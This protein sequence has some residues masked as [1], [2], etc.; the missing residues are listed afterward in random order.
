M[1]NEQRL[2]LLKQDMT[3]NGTL[4]PRYAHSVRTMEMA[5]ELNKRLNL[6][7]DEEKIYLAAMFHDCAK[8]LPEE[9]QFSIIKNNESSAFC[10]SVKDSPLVWHSFAGAYY[11]K[12]RYGILD[13]EVLEAIKYHTTGKPNMSNLEMLIFAS[14]YIES[15]RVGLWFDNA[16][17]MCYNNLVFGVFTILKQTLEYLNKNNCKIFY[18][19]KDTYTYY[20]KIVE[21]Q[22]A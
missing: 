19:T 7:I 17:K 1:T 22:N 14:D 20:Q 11:A 2:E 12:E 15:G 10:E 9:Q 21:E 3:I 18:L 16:R 8:L 4:H 5:L 6:N 13:E